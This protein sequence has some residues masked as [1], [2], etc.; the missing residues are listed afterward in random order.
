MVCRVHVCLDLEDKPRHLLFG[1][2]H[3]TRLSCA[4]LRQRCVDNKTVEHLLHTKVAECGSKKHRRDFATQI[5][6]VIEFM[7]RAAYQLDLFTELVR[8][9]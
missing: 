3:F 6:V 7:A 4:G 1:W 9:V 2:R 8:V 5:G